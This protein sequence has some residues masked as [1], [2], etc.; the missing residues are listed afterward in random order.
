M[1]F[2]QNLNNRV[3]VTSI[4]KK[5]SFKNV[6]LGFFTNLSSEKRVHLIT[7]E[8]AIVKIGDK[9]LAPFSGRVAIASAWKGAEFTRSRAYPASNV[10]IFPT[11]RDAKERFK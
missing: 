11:K 5:E 1:K 4:Y 2:S 6:V 8:D 3:L 7:N 9:S 10:S